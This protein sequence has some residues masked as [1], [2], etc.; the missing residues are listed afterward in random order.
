MLKERREKLFLK[1]KG[2]R[3]IIFTIVLATLLCGAIILLIL[4]YVF[5][6]LIAKDISIALI[7]LLGGQGFIR[8]FEY[9]SRKRKEKEKEEEILVAFKKL[10]KRFIYHWDLGSYRPPFYSLMEDVRL[11]LEKNIVDVLEEVEESQFKEIEE[12]YKIVSEMK[13]PVRINKDNYKSKSSKK[14]DIKQ[15]EKFINTCRKMLE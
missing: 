5:D 14:F 9:L 15:Y 8:S 13:I 11:F 3:N 12:M 10:L 1:M 6:V 2:K 7:V 4:S